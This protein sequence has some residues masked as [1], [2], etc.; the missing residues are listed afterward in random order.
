[1]LDKEELITFS[2]C[3]THLHGDLPTRGSILLYRWYSPTGIYSGIGYLPIR[4]DQAM[5]CVS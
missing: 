1:M 3:Q 2:R 4:F 5:P